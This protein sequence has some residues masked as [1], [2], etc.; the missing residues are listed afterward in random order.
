M[1]KE[2]IEKALDQNEDIITYKADKDFR[3]LT[4]SE[5]TLLENNN[6]IKKYIEELKQE[7]NKLNKMIDEMAV[8]LNELSDRLILAEDTDCF[9]PREYSNIDDCVRKTS[10]ADCIKRYFKEKVEGNK[11]L[12]HIKEEM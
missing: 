9:I 12:I 8:K 10:C 1:S 11:C 3:S 5:K 7:N 4:S 6:K 2:E